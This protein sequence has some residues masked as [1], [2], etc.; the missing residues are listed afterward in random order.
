MTLEVN[1]YIHVPCKGDIYYSSNR[2]EFVVVLDRTEHI[3]YFIC[4]S[5][6]TRT[7]I[8]ADLSMTKK[9]GWHIWL[10]VKEEFW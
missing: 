6:K 7:K 10:S 8:K 3:G 4:L 9:M 2:D 5:L 1:Q